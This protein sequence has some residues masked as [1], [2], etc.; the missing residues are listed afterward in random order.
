MKGYKKKPVFIEVFAM[1][2]LISPIINI[3]NIAFFYKGYSAVDNL[4][5]LKKLIMSGNIVVILNVI[6]WMS[7]IPLAIG[8]FKVRLWAWYYFILHSLGMLFLS[9]FTF[10]GSFHVSKASLINFLFLIPL[11]YYISREIRT[12]YF[13]PRVRWWEQAKRLKHNI[14]VMLHD[15][16][17]M[18]YDISLAGAFIITNGEINL[19]QGDMV[20][21]KLQYDNLSI[22]TNAEIVWEN[23]QESTLPIGYGIK[24][25]D[26]NKTNKK[27]LD[28]LISKLLE[29]GK[30]LH[31]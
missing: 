21:C 10:Q 11:G 7:A 29:E 6:G 23:A 30:Q 17:F 19:I 8:L 4:L 2:Y 3:L 5:R 28:K 18:T 14:D 16:S 15:K 20:K 9:F 24:F 27:L 25:V 1:I 13:N 12:P 31:R 26:L 22:E